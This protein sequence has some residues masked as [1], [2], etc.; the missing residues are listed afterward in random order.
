MEDK[1]KNIYN[2][3]SIYLFLFMDV[4]QEYLFL[5]Y[6][7]TYMQIYIYIFTKID[8]YIVAYL[9]LEIYR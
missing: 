2:I 8:I 7:Y 9:F 5:K 3:T 6:V 4:F 1:L